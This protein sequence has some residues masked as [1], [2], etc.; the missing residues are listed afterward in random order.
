MPILE[1][2]RTQGTS[3]GTSAVCRGLGGM[4]WTNCA[5]FRMVMVGSD[6]GPCWAT[7]LQ[8][9]GYPSLSM[10]LPAPKA[11]LSVRNAPVGTA[12]MLKE[13]LSGM[14]AVWASES[15]T[16]GAL[17]LLS[18]FQAL[19]SNRCLMNSLKN[20]LHFPGAEGDAVPLLQLRFPSICSLSRLL[21]EA[22]CP[23][24]LGA[25]SSRVNLTRCWPFLG[26]M[27]FGGDDGLSAR[28]LAPCKPCLCVKHLLT[29]SVFFS[30]LI[31]PL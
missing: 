30:L 10:A 20:K 4:E 15:S 12:Q 28:K 8:T 27:H 6:S 3:R 24:P 1:K 17:S 11:S 7:A 2:Q 29:C 21:E 26:A 19:V 23:V 5:S 16:Y 22:R 25:S 13:S 31:F 9:L 18:Q 14:E